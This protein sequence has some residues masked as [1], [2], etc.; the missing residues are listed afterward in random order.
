MKKAVEDRMEGTARAAKG[1]VKQEAGR[2]T[3]NGSM[4]AEGFAEKHLGKAQRA[5]GRMRSRTDNDAP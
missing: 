2:I 4:Q 1:K 3:R 5:A